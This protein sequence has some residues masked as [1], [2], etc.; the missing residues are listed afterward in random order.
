M[1]K[2]LMMQE[3]KYPWTP[4]KVLYE[5]RLESRNALYPGAD[6]REEAE[7]ACEPYLKYIIDTT[8]LSQINDT[9]HLTI[10]NSLNHTTNA[11]TLALS[12]TRIPTGA[13]NEDELR[14]L[15][16]SAYEIEIEFPG[17]LQ[18]MKDR[19]AYNDSDQKYQLDRTFFLQPIIHTWNERA[20]KIVELMK[21]FEANIPTLA[22]YVN[23]IRES[24][25]V[26]LGE[27]IGVKVQTS[28][29]PVVLNVHT[30]QGIPTYHTMP[31]NSIVYVSTL[32]GLRN[33]AGAARTS[34]PATLTGVNGA[35]LVHS[36]TIS[37]TPQHLLLT[38]NPD[39]LLNKD[40]TYQLTYALQQW[41]VYSSIIASPT[42]LRILS[43]VS[44]DTGVTES[45]NIAA[46]FRGDRMTIT[47]ESDD[48][49][50]VRVQLNSTKT[51]LGVIGVAAG[52]A[53]VTLTGTNPSGSVSTT[54][55]VTV[56]E[57]SGD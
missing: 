20:V 22:S 29:D 52:T 38:D 45:V 1:A 10:Q 4:H 44:L 42:V 31:A 36:K 5:N 23:F 37:G 50:K 57:A 21:W 17:L 48:T 41:N 47:A 15:I 19:V 24:A 39:H 40:A 11:N 12:N 35:S 6:T 9:I 51:S 54:L 7:R 28:S 27:K 13:F 18:Q 8:L 53:T 14:F 56:T 33:V 32:N 25:M 26:Q 55:E 43:D 49:D 34:R 2:E 46:L 16:A 3:L 30:D